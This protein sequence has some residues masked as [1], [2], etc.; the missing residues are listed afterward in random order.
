[1]QP[2]LLR[3]ISGSGSKFV[4]PVRVR[5]EPVC[6]IGANHWMNMVLAVIIVNY[7]TPEY[8]LAC[9]RSL[10][11]EREEFKEFQVFL[12]ENGSKDGSLER[13]GA[14][15]RGLGW[16]SWVE[17]LPQ[18]ENLGY[19]RANNLA[20]RRALEAT[21]ALEYVLLL[22]NDTV[23]HEGCFSAMISR[24]RSDPTIGALS[25]MVRNPDGSVQNVCRRFPRP[26]LATIRAM[27][28]PYVFPSLFAWADPEDRGWNREGAVRK[29]DWIGGAFM[30]L[31]ASA[32]RRAGAF[33]ERFFFYG[34]DAELCF[35][36][37]RMGWN[38]VFDSAGSITHHGGASSDAPRCPELRRIQWR[39]AAR[40]RFQRICYGALAEVWMRGIYTVFVAFNL[41]AMAVK[42][43]RGS[44]HWDRTLLD[45]RVLVKGRLVI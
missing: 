22:N 39:W 17:L 43:R 25:C 35:R 37:K 8:T 34:E 41:L 11:A 31:R 40:F 30:M 36:L 28:L 26:D 24:M 33:D 14:E 6:F 18:T 4:Q 20:V 27:G 19:A 10:A 9:I 16:S 23:V 38:V 42:G 2:K 15:I 29:V 5:E 44:S 13:L 7:R 12:V 3:I 32:L 45:L 1:M 21:P